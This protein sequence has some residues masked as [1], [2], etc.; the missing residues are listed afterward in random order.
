[1]GHIAWQ[2]D[3]GERAMTL[4]LEAFTI[5]RETQNAEGIFH[6]AR[7]LGR[8]LASAEAPDKARQLLQLAVEVGKAAGFPAVQEVEAELHRLPPAEV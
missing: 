8:V 1:M 7:T 4:W 2:A 6:T 5:A 3:D